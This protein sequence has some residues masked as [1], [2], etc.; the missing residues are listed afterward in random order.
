[1]LRI[2]NGGMTNTEYISY[3]SL[4]AISKAPLLI[5]GDVTNMSQATLNIYLNR[6]VIAINQDPLGI[7]GKK[8]V[9][10]SSKSFNNVFSTKCSIHDQRQKWIYDAKNDHIRSTSNGQCLTINKCDS[11]V[12]LT[13]IVTTTCFNNT[14][15]S[16][17]PRKLQQWMINNLWKWNKTDGLIR[18]A[19]NTECLTVS[20]IT[21]IWAGPLSDESQA[22]LLFNRNSTTSEVITIKW[23]DLGWSANQRASVRDLWTH[24]DLGV[25]LGSYTSPSIERHAVQMLKIT[26]VH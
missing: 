3:F 8:I 20:Q 16:S 13:N 22:V 26:R 6:E 7:Q 2:G 24:Q 1:M 21:E 11:D 4:W 18:N 19:V 9:V 14:F 23:T 17:C 10:S 15:K 25:F 12:E 5:G